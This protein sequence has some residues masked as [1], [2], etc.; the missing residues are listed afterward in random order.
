MVF[1]GPSEYGEGEQG[2][3]LSWYDYQHTDGRVATRFDD[4]SCSDPD[5]AEFLDAFTAAQK[6]EKSLNKPLATL[7]K[8]VIRLA[9]RTTKRLITMIDRKEKL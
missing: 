8:K 9:A 2:N 3:A 7:Q 6:P 1:A 4:G 5:L